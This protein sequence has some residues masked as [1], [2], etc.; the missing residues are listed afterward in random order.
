[1][2]STSFLFGSKAVVRA[3]LFALA[4]SSTSLLACETHAED[5]GDQTLE[6]HRPITRK[7]RSG[8]THSYTIRIAKGKF[9]HFLVDQQAIHATLLLMRPDGKQLS[10][11][12]APNSRNGWQQLSVVTRSTENYCLQVTGVASGSSL[13]AYRIEWTD[14]RT[15]T[16]ADSERVKAEKSLMGAV[17]LSNSK[18][19]RNEQKALGVLQ[20]SVPLWRLLNDLDGQAAAQL[21]M[22]S[23]Y[24]SLKQSDTAQVAYREALSLEHTAGHPRHAAQIV[25]T[26]GRMYEADH[27]PQPALAQFEQSLAMWRLVRDR[28]EEAAALHGLGDSHF[29]LSEFQKA[30][31]NYQ[32]AASLWETAGD[33]K[34]QATALNDLGRTYNRLGE[35]QP[36]IAVY[37]QSLSL[38]RTLGEHFYEAYT[39]DSLGT[40]YDLLGDRRKGLDWHNQALAVARAVGDSSQIGVVLD[41]VARDYGAL[42]DHEKALD[43]YQEAFNFAED[44]S[45]ALRNIGNTYADLNDKTKSLDYLNRG[46]A[47]SRA[48]RDRTGEASALVDLAR[49]HARFGDS[50]E[51]INFYSQG[52]A[53]NRALGDRRGEAFALDGLAGEHFKLSHYQNALEAYQQEL[54]LWQAEGDQQWQGI[55][56]NSIA[57]SYAR[58]HDDAR[59]IDSY[60]HALA[61]WRK[62]G[63]RDWEAT[64][65]M[66]LGLTYAGL[67]Q[68]E[69]AIEPFRQALEARLA[70][71]DRKAAATSASFLASTYGDLE[72]YP[73]ELEYQNQELSLWQAEGDKKKQGDVLYEMASTTSNLGDQHKALEYLRQ[74]IEFHKSAAD[75]EA[76]ALDTNEIAHV[77]KALDQFPQALDSYNSA[78]ALWKRKNDLAWQGI[79]LNNI[80][81]IY[82]SLGQYDRALELYKQSLSASQAAGEHKY[83][84]MTLLDIGSLYLERNQEANARD[85]FDRAAA[86]AVQMGDDSVKATVLKGAGSSFLIHGRWKIAQPYLVQAQQL[87]HASDDPGEAIVLIGLATTYLWG[88]DRDKAMELYDQAIRRADAAGNQVV[89]I[90]ALDMKAFQQITFGQ[91]QDALKTLQAAFAM[92]PT[93]H[94]PMGAGYTTL[95]LAVVY[96]NLDEDLKAL[97]VAKLSLPVWEAAGNRPMQARLLGIESMTYALTGESQKALETLNRLLSL[98]DSKATTGQSSASLN[99][100]PGLKEGQKVALVGTKNEAFSLVESFFDREMEAATI[101]NIGYCYHA[102]GDNPKALEFYQKALSFARNVPDHALEALLLKNIGEAYSESHDYA[103]ALEMLQQALQLARS[104]KNIQAEALTLDSIGATQSD[105]G[106]YAQAREYLNQALPLV[107]TIGRRTYEARV[108]G[109]LAVTDWKLGE[110]KEAISK[111]AQAL[112]MARAVQ[113]VPQE[114]KILATLMHCWKEED[115]SALA[116]FFGKQ[117]INAYQQLRRNISGLDKGMQ[118]TFVHSKEDSYR[119]LAEL[120]IQQGRLP[121]AQQ[122]LASLKDQEY[123]DFLRHDARG[124]ENPAAS[125]PGSEK[126]V[127]FQKKYRQVSDQLAAAGEQWFDLS[128]KPSRTSEEE[129]QLAELSN[130]LRLANQAMD[131]FFDSF[132]AE[133]GKSPMAA[134]SIDQTK[135][136]ASEL[137]T[138]LQDLPSGTVVLYT[139]VGEDAYHVILVTRSVMLPREYKISAKQLRQKVLDFLEVLRD[140]DANPVPAARELYQIMI[141]PVAKDLAGMRARTLMWSLDDVLRYV[142]VAALNDGHSYLVENYRN[143]IF[144]PASVPN[145]PKKPEIKVWRGVGMGSSS[146]Y[147]DFQPLPSVPVELHRVIRDSSAGNSEGVVPGQIMLDSEFTKAGLERALAMKYPL[148]H[149]ASH[150]S[151]RPGDEM[152][153]FLL[154]GGAGN[155][156]QPRRLTLAEIRDDPRITFRSVELL[157]LSACDTASGGTTA[158]GKEVEGFGR[159]AQ[160]KGAQA[161]VATLWEVDDESTGL[162]MQRFYK[163]WMSRPGISKAEALR[164]AQV[165]LLRGNVTSQDTPAP[166]SPYEHP[167]F[168]APFILIGNWQ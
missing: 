144:T 131:Q 47:A 145:L 146:G 100:L 121:E 164:L 150:F 156:T 10:V 25:L 57:K 66:S 49:A 53:A 60:N 58:L 101:G 147:E 81:E 133:L 26:M 119:D 87:L 113:D 161:V 80:A 105:Q 73:K 59:S 69:K 74:A 79:T 158:D 6:P 86:V 37:Q 63:D 3:L 52:L 139:L 165:S 51:A 135:E 68:N 102:L 2:N 27:Q 43:A 104:L 148:V 16:A 76:E 167:Y 123:F 166:T 12:D 96:Q 82:K 94:S 160:Q 75:V 14:L 21:A 31:E 85:Q 99:R 42:G 40:T 88:G 124:A 136:G 126:E 115:N 106:N 32:E 35:S 157:T 56:F 84:A 36:A 1:M 151:F 62:L 117:S 8:E 125:L 120:L 142:P 38:W 137:Q 111:L 54:L 90:L 122:V 4:M 143:E 5:P 103:K 64:T 72:N 108:L 50:Q 45:S 110:R 11:M 17:R 97:E 28:Q 9:A 127:E 98:V 163:I 92:L 20:S 83:E 112:S 71:G 118:T 30:K 39:L 46:L 78:L 116:I 159:M 95:A 140:P 67:R 77:H 19:K 128:A 70:L 152:D 138:A 153:S 7:L 44:K 61:I 132:Y 130:K 24:E 141:G 48:S 149:I 18:N 22:A 34:M 29:D 55:T 162:L 155:D 129:M 107:H 13:G 134:K 114:A 109:H 65:L 33:Q 15:A 168:W 91:Y 23:I 41:S 154:L 93:A 89:E